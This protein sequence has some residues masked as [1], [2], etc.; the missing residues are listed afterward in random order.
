[1]YSFII[2]LCVIL[3]RNTQIWILLDKNLIYSISSFKSFSFK[4]WTSI[5]I[6]KFKFS[7]KVLIIFIFNSFIFNALELLAII[8][9]KFYNNKIKMWL[10]PGLFGGDT[11]VPDLSGEGWKLKTWVLWLLIAQTAISI[12]QLILFDL[13]MG[14]VGLLTAVILYWGM[15]Q[16]NYWMILF[17]NTM[18]FFTS[19]QIFAELGI[20]V[21]DTVRGK[22]YDSYL[23]YHKYNSTFFVCYLSFIFL[24]NV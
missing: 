3:I 7:I 20:Y 9:H 19:I 17:Y 11:P 1:M 22:S 13:M 23:N 5:L 14:I 16:N 2:N 15:T 8:R 21:Q 24:F 18:I 6:L 10:F 4:N 12:S